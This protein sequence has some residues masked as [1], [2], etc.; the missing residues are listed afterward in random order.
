MMGMPQ[1]SSDGFGH[2]KRRQAYRWKV[3]IPCTVTYGDTIIIGRI[4]NLSSAGALITQVGTVPPKGALVVVRIQMEEKKV[5]LEVRLTCRV[6]H[7]TTQEI[8]Q[9]GQLGSFGVE[10]QQPV[11]AVISKLI[12]VF[13]YLIKSRIHRAKG[14]RSELKRRWK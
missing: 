4:A 14:R 5:E 10:F 8:I 13:C 1:E 3:A 12:P 11:E 9:A 7:H 2:Q 6:A